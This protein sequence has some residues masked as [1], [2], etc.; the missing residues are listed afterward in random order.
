MSFL[1]MFGNNKKIM[2]RTEWVMDDETHEK[3]DYI[4]STPYLVP[5]AETLE[6]Y[7]KA[8]DDGNALIAHDFFYR[9]DGIIKRREMRLR[10]YGFRNIIF[11]RDGDV[12]VIEGDGLFMKKDFFEERQNVSNAE[13]AVRAEMSYKD[14][15][16]FVRSS[17]GFSDSDPWYALVFLFRMIQLSENGKAAENGKDTESGKDEAAG[18]PDCID[19]ENG[20]GPG[21]GRNGAE[22]ESDLTTVF[23]TDDEETIRSVLET[24]TE[25]VDA[26]R[27]KEEKEAKEREEKE[28][29]KK[30]SG[31]RLF[32]R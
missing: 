22:Y 15:R 9:V 25:K 19:N 6:R 17:N 4:E 18:V 24:V 1:G 29:E 28:A 13:C 2:K 27:E 20:A 30:K 12:Y 8:A 26:V 21:N 10:D 31:R 11:C 14:R 3:R 32:F 5:A 16:L 7:L 23:L